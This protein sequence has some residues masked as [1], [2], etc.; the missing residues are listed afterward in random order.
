MAQSPTSSAV[1]ALQLELKK[2]QEEPVEGFRVHLINEDNIFEWEVAIFGP[3][4]TL[5]EGGYFK[6]KLS[7]TTHLTFKYFYCSSLRRYLW[8][9]QYIIILCLNHHQV[10]FVYNRLAIYAWRAQ[11]I[12]MVIVPCII[13]YFSKWH[14]YN[15][16]CIWY[17]FVTD[18]YLC[19]NFMCDVWLFVCLKK[20]VYS[21]HFPLIS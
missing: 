19:W 1:R 7:R 2:I 14:S 3:P 4:G 16:Y 12:K 17:I 15:V 5:Y 18:S 9:P 8:Y 6:V 20:C 13:I 21:L 10:L 11:L